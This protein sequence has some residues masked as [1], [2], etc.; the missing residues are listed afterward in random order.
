VRRQIGRV[1]WSIAFCTHAALCSFAEGSSEVLDSVRVRLNGAGLDTL[2]DHAVRQATKAA[3]TRC[4][5]V[6]TFIGDRARER[7]L[8]NGLVLSVEADQAPA[9]ARRNLQFVLGPPTLVVASGGRWID[10]ESGGVEDKLH[11]H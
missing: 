1:Q 3:N 9:I 11:L 6:A 4:P 8:A 10:P 5:P 7:D 2:V